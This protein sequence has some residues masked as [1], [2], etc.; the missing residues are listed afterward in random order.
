MGHKQ[1]NSAGPSC[2]QWTGTH[3]WWWCQ[4]EFM[5]LVMALQDISMSLLTSS[6]ISEVKVVWLEVQHVTSSAV[7]TL[8]NQQDCSGG[9]SWQACDKKWCQSVYI[10]I[11][12]WK[13]SHPNT[14][15]RN[16]LSIFV[17]LHFVVVSTFLAQATDSSV[18]KMVAPSPVCELLTCMTSWHW[19]SWTSCN[20]AY[21][22]EL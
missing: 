4:A 20:L 17:Y 15:A 2:I 22:G 9:S 1:W 8:V 5:V 6:M 16:S 21:I 10:Y 3:G 14:S 19:R 18:L 13:C 12:V 7:G 11:Y